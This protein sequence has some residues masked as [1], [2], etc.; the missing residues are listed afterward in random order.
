[1]V[2]HPTDSWWLLASS[3]FLSRSHQVPLGAFESLW[4]TTAIPTYGNTRF[5]N[6]TT[7]DIF[8]TGFGSSSSATERF[9]QP[10]F[11]T[12]KGPPR[13]R[14]QNTCLPFPI[15]DFPAAACPTDL[16]R[17]PTLANPAM[18]YHTSAEHIEDYSRSYST[19]QRR[20]SSYDRYNDDDDSSVTDSNYTTSTA[21]SRRSS[22]DLTAP[23]RGPDRSPWVGINGPSGGSDPD[24]HELWCEFC[25]I[26]NCDEEFHISEGNLW[27]NHHLHHLSHQLPSR[28]VCWF[29][30]DY[31]FT[32]DERADKAE[33]Q[34][35]FLRRMWHIHD[36]IF[37]DPRLTL[38]S[39]RPDFW[40]AA[41]LYRLGKIGDEVYEDI[42]NYTELPPQLRIPGTPGSVSYE[43]YHQHGQ[44]Q[45]R[46]SGPL[47]PLTPPDNDGWYRSPQELRRQERRRQR[48]ERR[49]P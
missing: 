38:E 28:L 21:P 45:G 25:G 12:S 6:R 18:S 1:M 9:T 47:G 42:R 35:N 40:M 49:R 37:D 10:G 29:C 48:P 16:H 34:Q 33:R 32:V 23:T 24:A 27:I 15:Q 31:E 26:L 8:I 44:S 2:I 39:M 19:G 5:A 14:K 30:N 41:H 13:W 3:S 20:Q 7:S 46:Q 22:T 11:Q 17:H 36:H 43:R 4:Y